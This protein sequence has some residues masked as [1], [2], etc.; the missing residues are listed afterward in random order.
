M[1]L[2]KKLFGGKGKRPPN[3]E[4][5]TPTRG[6][7]LQY[8]PIPEN[9]PKFAKQFVDAVSNNENKE[10]DYGVDTLDFVDHFLQRFRDEGLNVN[11]FAETIFVA[12][13]YVG[14]VMIKNNQGV[15]IKQ[16]DANLPDGVSMMSIVIK[17][18][19]GNVVDPIAKAFK[20]FHY[21]ESDSIR[22]FYQVFTNE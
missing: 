15:W 22:Y 17:L 2:F 5:P 19:N 18:P 13:A 14:E 7:N 8:Q 11:D 1:N 6:L 4:G 16:E 12:G 10:L 20:R 21:G 3:D 9:G